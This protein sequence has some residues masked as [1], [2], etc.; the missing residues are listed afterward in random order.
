MELSIYFVCR[1]QANA[2]LKAPTPS[3]KKKLCKPFSTKCT[4]K[5]KQRWGKNWPEYIRYE[6]ISF[7]C[8][9]N[10]FL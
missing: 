2:L 8:D 3:K 1:P 6:N 5:L 4:E 9:L 7:F 10:I